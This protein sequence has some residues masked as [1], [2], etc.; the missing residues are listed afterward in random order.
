MNADYTCDIGNLVNFLVS[1]LFCS[2]TTA[3]YGYITPSYA[4]SETHFQ[5]CTSFRNLPFFSRQFCL[6]FCVMLPKK[7]DLTK[8]WRKNTSRLLFRK[9]EGF[10]VP[11]FVL[12]SLGEIGLKQDPFGARKFGDAIV[13]R[14]ARKMFTMLHDQL[15]KVFTVT[16]PELEVLLLRVFLD[17]IYLRSLGVPPWQ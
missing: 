12:K 17:E 14:F 3:R 4:M 16:T 9:N 7:S 8:S 5:L 10:G 2:P 11:G 6:D 13:A 15:Y 1:K